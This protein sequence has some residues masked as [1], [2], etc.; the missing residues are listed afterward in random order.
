M[1]EC[2][3]KMMMSS[4][5]INYYNSDDYGVPVGFYPVDNTELTFDAIQ[6]VPIKMGNR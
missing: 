3:D 4:Y 5:L 6:S 1:G 2:D